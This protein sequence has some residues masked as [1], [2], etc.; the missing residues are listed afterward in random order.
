MSVNVCMSANL[1]ARYVC[2]CVCAKV[3]LCVCVGVHVL[4]GSSHRAAD[5][6]IKEPLNGL[7]LVNS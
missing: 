4:I 5:G 7:A 6:S 2:V 1:C 3:C